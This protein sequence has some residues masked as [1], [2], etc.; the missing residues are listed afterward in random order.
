MKLYIRYIL[1]FSIISPSIGSS[2]GVFPYLKSTKTTDLN[3]S[4]HILAIRVEFEEDNDPRTTGNGKFL[5]SVDEN[6][7]YYNQSEK[8]C[9]GFLLDPPPHNKEYFEDQIKAAKNYYLNIS[10]N[11]I[12]FDYHV[13]DPIYQ[14]NKTMIEYSEISGYDNS[15]ESI[16]Q[17]FVDA[18][19]KADTDINTYLEENSLD[20][21]ELLIVVFH[22]GVGED[23]GFDGYI[24]PANYDIRSAYI[25]SDI[26]SFFP[27]SVTITKGILLP[28]TLNLLYYNTIEDIYGYQGQGLCDIQI[29][30]TG[31]FTYLLGYEFGLPE[32]FNRDTG[33]TGLGV[34]ELMD[35]GSFNGRGTIPAPPQAWSRIQMGWEE[36]DLL[37][38]GSNNYIVNRNRFTD[39]DINP[40]VHRVNISKDEYFLLESVNN[41]IIEGED[42]YDISEISYMD[43]VSSIYIPDTLIS[44]FDRLIYLNESIDDIIDYGT[45]CSDNTKIT[46]SNTTGVIL[47]AQ[48]YDYGLPGDGMM[49]WRINE[50]NIDNLND[51]INNKTVELIEAD[52]AQDIGYQNYFYPIANPSIGWMWDLWFEN[53]EAYFSVNTEQS[54]VGLNSYT[55]PST[56]SESGARSLISISDIKESTTSSG[57]K[58]RFDYEDDIFNQIFISNSTDI[59]CVGNGYPG[60]NFLFFDTGSEICLYTE[61]DSF[62]N[63]NDFDES[64]YQ[65]GDFIYFSN[66]ESFG[67]CAID[68]YYD[69]EQNACVSL[70]GYVSKGYFTNSIISEEIPEQFKDIELSKLA[71]GDIDQDGFD[72]IIE[73]TDS[74]ITCY[75]GNGTICNGFPVPGRFHGN[76]VIGN[77]KGD[78]D[79]YPEIMVRSDGNINFISHNGEID[80]QI[81][82]QSSSNLYLTDIVSTEEIV[83][84]DGNRLLYLNIEPYNP[85][86]SDDYIYWGAPNSQ[87]NNQPDVTGSHSSPDYS[88]ESRIS[89]FYNYPNPTKDDKTIFRYFISESDKA[90]I[91]IYSSSGF[92]IKEISDITFGLNEY[93]EVFWDARDQLP[94]L[95]LANL[96]IYKNGKQSDSKFTKVLVGSR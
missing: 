83:L 54:D 53:N 86:S 80:Y 92:L 87:F 75:N 62:I 70:Q 12:N 82:S 79:S 41:N 55:I 81:S 49:I 25:D 10:N 68:E 78:D 96:I 67:S 66:L 28:E 35:I 5:T 33:K 74:Y 17:L 63:C 27:N 65:P 40:T 85:Y 13:L 56:F 38:T 47:C 91:K 95:Y 30:M 23:Y 15:N 24:D 46:I 8:R 59:I 58:F 44:I 16:A 19:E 84:S 3:E 60:S 57:I 22:A 89:I 71:L 61:N 29:G 52:G 90:E 32:M 11:Q 18:L 45:E 21:S 64:F 1:F 73:M 39:D 48:N 7:Y 2:N 88:L 42:D 72:E 34:F 14:L 9:E 31:L 43:T 6:I 94:G 69:M 26:A 77:L 93:N 4:I 20:E 36:S 51:D 76:I 50:E 37:F